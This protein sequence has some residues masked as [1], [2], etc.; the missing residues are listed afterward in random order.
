MK[1]KIILAVLLFSFNAMAQL[2]VQVSN[3]GYKQVESSIAVHPS[4][5]DISAVATIELIPT[6]RQCLIY[7]SSDNGINWTLKKSINNATDPVIEFDNNGNL[8]FTYLH[9]SE[10]EVYIIKSTNLGVTWSVPL[11]V[12]NVTGYDEADKEWIVIQ[13]CRGPF[14]DNNMLIL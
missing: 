14:L 4:N 7:L 12:S 6:G 10:F 5:S 9:R 13:G 8:F 2:P 1:V 3:N 11:K